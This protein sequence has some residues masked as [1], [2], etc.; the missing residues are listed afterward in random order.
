LQSPVIAKVTPFWTIASLGHS[1]LHVPQAIHSS[2]TTT[3][4][5]SLTSLTVYEKIS[6]RLQDGPRQFSVAE[7]PAGC[8]VRP[9]GLAA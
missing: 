9:T 8:R 3:K 6:G 1:T 7:K 2:A 4:A 5:N